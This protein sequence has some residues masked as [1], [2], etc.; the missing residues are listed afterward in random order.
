VVL[1]ASN[2]IPPNLTKECIDA[3]IMNRVGSTLDEEPT[4]PRDKG[5][6]DASSDEEDNEEEVSVKKRFDEIKSNLRNNKPD[7]RDTAEL[8]HFAAQNA[9][10]LGETTADGDHNTLLHLLVEDAK[11]KVFDKYQP[12][13]KLLIER[14]PNLLEEKDSSDKTPLYIAIS[15]KRHKLV[16]FVCDTHPKIH[17]ILSIPCYRSENCLHLAIRRVTPDLAVF[18]IEHA[19]E[20]A[21]CAQDDKGNTPL[22][23]AV[24]YERCTDAQLR[25]VKALIRRCDKAID[26]RTKE[27]NHFSPYLFH[28]HTRA[29][30]KIAAEAE[31]KKAAKEKEKEAA[32]GKKDEDGVASRNGMGGKD[33]TGGKD[34]AGAKFTGATQAKD[35]KAPRPVVAPRGQ[36]AVVW[37][38]ESEN[39]GQSSL[40]NTSG[41]TPSGKYG[42]AGGSYNEHKGAEFGPGKLRKVLSK[43]HTGPGGVGSGD[44]KGPNQ[45]TPV[46]LKTSAALKKSKR[47]EKEKEEKVTEESADAIRYYLKLHCLRSRDHD[48]AVDF[49][50][51]RNQ[52]LSLHSRSPVRIN[53][54]G[55]IYDIQKTRSIS[56]SMTTPP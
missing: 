32:Q 33:D 9:N 2:T 14:Y 36:S 41:E 49:L 12:L 35:A 17:A 8:E 7:L 51:G 26:K 39:I 55:K 31:A 45:K 11:D 54:D 18:L 50:Y 23:L 20:A 30:A 56:T 43:V 48:E 25:I 10:Y 22:H 5:D 21:L 4:L 29:E 13:I 34:G 47:K 46:A 38:T 6:S 27:P 1:Y 19:D 24:A 52:G 40:V 37:G 16:R 3:P 53:A 28:E 42:S 15:K 44:G